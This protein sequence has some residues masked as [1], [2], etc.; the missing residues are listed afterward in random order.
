MKANLR[1]F[2]AKGLYGLLKVASDMYY[3]IRDQMKAYPRYFPSGLVKHFE[4]GNEYEMDGW[5]DG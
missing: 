2:P 4:V 3:S 1:G 5:M